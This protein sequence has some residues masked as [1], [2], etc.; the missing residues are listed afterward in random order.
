MNSPR[1]AHSHWTIS[2]DIQAASLHIFQLL[3]LRNALLAF[4]SSAS[5]AVATGAETKFSQGRSL[6]RF[7]DD[8]VPATVTTLNRF[9][10]FCLV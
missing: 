1:E 10:V 2:C 7:F 9:L 6:E 4:F 3:L 5:D 8:M